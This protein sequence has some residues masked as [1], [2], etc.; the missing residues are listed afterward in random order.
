MQ[1]NDLLIKTIGSAP[2]LGG[3]HRLGLAVVIPRNL[4]LNLP[5]LALDLPGVLAVS[6]ISSNLAFW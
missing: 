3:D 6:G 5:E 1:G 2:A 4:D